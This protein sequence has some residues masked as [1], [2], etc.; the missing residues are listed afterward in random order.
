MNQEM[1]NNGISQFQENGETVKQPNGK[2]EDSPKNG[3]T[4]SM[5]WE[6]K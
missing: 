2:F 1:W 6:V 5:V 3:Y 4:V